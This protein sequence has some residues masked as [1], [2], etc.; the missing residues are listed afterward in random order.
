MYKPKITTLETACM[1]E[2]T[3][4]LLGGI[5]D[6]CERL[7]EGTEAA[8]VLSVIAYAAREA[9]GKQTLYLDEFIKEYGFTRPLM[10]ITPKNTE[11]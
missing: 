11:T 8:G 6:A 1:L 4:L 5:A 9:W 2:E 10:D 7:S 3:A